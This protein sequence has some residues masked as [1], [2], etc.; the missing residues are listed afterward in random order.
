MVSAQVCVAVPCLVCP[1]VLHP[2]SHQKRE[3]PFRAK[4]GPLPGPKPGPKPWDGPPSGVSATHSR[5]DNAPSSVPESTVQGSLAPKPERLQR[6]VRQ[7]IMDMESPAP[8]GQHR[9][10]VPPSPRLLGPRAVGSAKSV[11]RLAEPAAI[12]GG[13]MTEPI[14]RGSPGTLQVA[15]FTRNQMAR[16]STNE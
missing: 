11:R 4:A 16:P 12:D 8:R 14:W 6:R 5:Q 1:C 7:G 9:S 13:L 2:S 3:F 15:W 10:R